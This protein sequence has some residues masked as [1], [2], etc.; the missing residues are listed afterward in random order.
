[1]KYENKT[2]DFRSIKEM[3]LEDRPR[4]KLL[5]AGPLGMS[6]IELLCL[7]VG[8]GSKRRPVQDIAQDILLLLN[9][10]GSCDIPVNDISE[11][12]GVGKANASRICACLE[13]GRRF[14]FFKPRPCKDPGRIFELVR[15]YG[16]RL[17]EHFLVIM[18]NGAH[19]L[20]GVNVVT[21]GLVN[22]TLVH[23]REVFSEPLKMRATA[24]VLAH[25]HPS[26]NLEPS[27][28]DLEVTFR[29]RQA[30]QILG[31]AVLDHIIFNTEGYMS[32]MESGEL[33]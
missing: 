17:Q 4:E 10:K 15:H 27:P 28:D 31:I 14:S 1:M 22:R 12:P 5:T 20:M 26:G 16:D 25:N 3:P 29:I 23:P 8:S 9:G 24:V 19:E 32:M 30:G 13:I 18:L 2:I 7:V 21:V 6:D 33:L 11:I